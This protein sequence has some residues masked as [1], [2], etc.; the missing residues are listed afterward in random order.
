VAQYVE[1]VDFHETEAPSIEAPAA[2]EQS[3]WVN[4]EVEVTVATYQAYRTMYFASIV[5]LGVAGLDKF[6][7]LLT[8]WELY[9]SP[10]L[11]SM[12]HMTSLGV[13]SLAGVVEIAIAIT[14]AL[15]PRIGSWA[16][17]VWLWLIVLNLLSVHGYYDVILWDLA[18]SA[19][20]FAFT[21]LSAECN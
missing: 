5:L 6:F 9:V 10:K 21:R 11:A 17:T 1:S 15:K 7:H 3:S 14:I 8:N 12:L 16:L 13:S 19:A 20:A 2:N 4:A 18:L